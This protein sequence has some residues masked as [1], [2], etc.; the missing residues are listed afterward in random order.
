MKTKYTIII[1]GIIISISVI[2]GA[3]FKMPLDGSGISFESPFT[4]E[5]YSIEITGMK[6]VYRIGEQYD[7][8]YVISGYGHSCGS[9]EITFPDQNGDVTSLHFNP[10]CIGGVPLKE[11]IVD[12]KKQHEITSVHG[13]INNPGTYNVTVTFDSPSRDSPTTAIHE[14]SVISSES[15]HQMNPD[16]SITSKKIPFDVEKCAFDGAKVEIP[17]TS[18]FSYDSISN[19]YD[20]ENNGKNKVP[21]QLVLLANSSGQIT[22]THDVNPNSD[23]NPCK[24]T[25]DDVFLYKFRKDAMQDMYGSADIHIV[26]NT[27]EQ[28]DFI[29]PENN[30]DPLQ[31]NLLNHMNMSEHKIQLTYEIKSNY[32]SDDHDNEEESQVFLI[33]FPFGCLG[34]IVTVG[35]YP[36]DEITPWK[37]GGPGS[38]AR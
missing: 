6:D 26:N 13:K 31:V 38:C 25:L 3:T 9:R 17:K 30:G 33:S 11:S 24:I 32:K 34:V 2:F 28:F 19:L 16:E 5:H 1:L 35:E 7:F 20:A 21:A 15:D 14:F 12:P 10:L 29:M 8:S 18:G 37:S 22:I 23:I 4:E 27:T 36:V